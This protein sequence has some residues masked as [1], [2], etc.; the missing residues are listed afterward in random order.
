VKGQLVELAR[1]VDGEGGEAALVH[2]A[3]WEE[4]FDPTPPARKVAG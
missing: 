4:D 2:R 1:M 3:L